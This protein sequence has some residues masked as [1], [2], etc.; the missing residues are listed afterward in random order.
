MNNIEFEGD[1]LRVFL[2]C[3]KILSIPLHK[4]PGIKKLTTIERS[5]YHI[6]GGISLDFEDPD[7]VYHINEFLGI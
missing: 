2:K 1:I 6:A 5:K 4:F 7:E 3:D